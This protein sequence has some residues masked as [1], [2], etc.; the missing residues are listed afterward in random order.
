M[1]AKIS[2]FSIDVLTRKQR[3]TFELDGDFRS[4]FDAL[5]GKELDLTV[6]LWKEKRSLDANAYLWVLIGKL[7]DEMNLPA[8]DIYR[9][10]IRQVGIYRDV[11]LSKDAAA[12]IEHIWSAHGIGW[13][14]EKVDETD[15]SETIRLYYGSSCY[16]TKQ[17]SRLID[18]VVADC[19][20]LGIETKTPKEL[21]LIL[22]D[23]ERKKAT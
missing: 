19:K 9:H 10:A 11:E 8:R 23:W 7:A 22:E 18:F 6:K 5:N 14:T 3:I 15:A 13:V 16:N 20:D 17:M 1:K 12:T 21:A 4:D 2:D